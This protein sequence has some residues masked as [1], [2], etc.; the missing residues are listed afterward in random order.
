MKKII[1]L[2]FFL[3]TIICSCHRENFEEKIHP[4]PRWIFIGYAIPWDWDKVDPVELATALH[5][6]GLNITLI[7]IDLRKDPQSVSDWI[8]PFRRFGIVVEIVLVNGNA[9]DSIQQPSEWFENYV[10][11]LKRKVGAEG[12][13]FQPVTEP[14][15]RGGDQDKIQH[16]ID[17]GLKEWPGP[18]V[19]NIGFEWSAPFVSR[20]GYL[21]KHHCKNPDETTMLSGIKYINTTDCTATL[22]MDPK[23]AA[24]AVRTAIQKNTN[25]IL[26]DGRLSH[27]FD[28]NEAL[29]KAMGDE[30]NSLW[31]S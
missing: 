2:L 13:L 25:F 7:E 31:W 8:K 14:G 20:A 21:E 18:T 29:L 15:A 5:R 24:L 11:E 19:I 16:W 9:T 28:I 10:Q 4:R 1:P 17:Y 22:G 26:Y 30:I 12:I 3:G 6:N 27:T 23:R